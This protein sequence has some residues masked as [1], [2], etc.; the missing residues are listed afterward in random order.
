MLRGVT[1]KRE[2]HLKP[3]LSSSFYFYFFTQ[4][5]LV[6]VFFF[7]VVLCKVRTLVVQL[8]KYNVFIGW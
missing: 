3:Q 4:F 2:V 5:E 8:D 1:G 7:V 6:K